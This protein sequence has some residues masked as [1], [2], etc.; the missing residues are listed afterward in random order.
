MSQLY[1]VAF[2]SLRDLSSSLWFPQASL[3][4]PLARNLGFIHFPPPVCVPCLCSHSGPNHRKR[5]GEKKEVEAC[6]ILW[7]SSSERKVPFPQNFRPLGP[8][9][10]SVAVGLSGAWHPRAWG[11]EKNK[12]T[13]KGFSPLF[14]Y[15]ETHSSSQ[16]PNQRVS[17][18]GV[19]IHRH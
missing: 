16:S 14:E 11:R 3:F 19:I 10:T 4:H 6:S 2:L 17:C 8:I 18:G 9:L 1:E 5:E 15:Q 7:A 12:Q 13:N